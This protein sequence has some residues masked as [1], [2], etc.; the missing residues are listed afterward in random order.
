[1]R[2]AASALLVCIGTIHAASIS[3]TLDVRDWIADYQRPTILPRA[4][5]A[6][7]PSDAKASLLLAN[8][9]FP[10]P[11]IE[12]TEGDSIE[13]HVANNLIEVQIALEFEGLKLVDGPTNPIPQ[14]GGQSKYVLVASTSGVFSWHS[15]VASQAASGLKGAIV[16]HSRRDPF[17]GK[18]K[19]EMVIALSDARQRPSVCFKVDGAV[20]AA[21]PEIEKATLN[22]QWGDGSKD[23]PL[24]VVNVVKGECYRVHFLGMMTQT[25][26]HFSIRIQ[27]HSVQLLNGDSSTTASE[28]EVRAGESADT[29]LCA[30]A[31][32]G[33]FSHD[34]TISFDY[35]GKTMSKSFSAV[36]RYTRASDVAH[37]AVQTSASV[38]KLDNML[39]QVQG[40]GASNQQGSDFD[41]SHCDVHRIFEVRDAIVD[42]L[43]PTVDLGGSASRK[44]PND[45]P[46]AVRKAALLVNDSYPGPVLEATEGQL[47]C[48]TVLN[49]CDTDPM[50]IHWHGQHMKGHPAFD[51]VYGVT[52]AAINPR[53]G[54]LTYRWKANKGTHMYHA[55]MQALQADRGLKGAIVIHAKND[56][57]KHLYDE[58]RIVTISDEWVNPGTCMRTEGAQPGNPVCSEIDKATWNGQWGDGSDEY[59]W[60]MVTVEKGKCYRLRFIGI[61]GQAQNFQIQIAGHNMTLIAVDGEDVEPV[62]VSSMNL[63]A[64]ERYDVVVCADQEEGNYLMSAVYDLATFLETLPAPK[65][66]K[67]DSSKYWAFLN[68]AG[69]TEKPGRASKK[70]LGGYNPPPGTGGGLN[71]KAAGGF[72]WDTNTQTA[73]SQ[74]KNLNPRPE[75]EKA[76]ITYVMDVGIARPAFQAGVTPYA[77]SDV[78][79]MFTNRSSWKKPS[80]PLLHTKGQCGAEGVPYITVP[81][82]VSTVEVIINNLSPTAHVLHMHGMDFSVINYAPFSES[83][84]SA[85]HFD[86]FFLPLSIAKKL[87]CKGARLGDPSKDGP[88]NEYW[89]C[90]YDAEKDVKSQMLENPL[91]KDMISLWRRSWAVIRFKV[92]NPGVWL[93][94]CHMEQHIPTGQIMAF[95]LLPS[96]QPPIPSDVPT[97]GDCPIWSGRLAPTRPPKGPDFFV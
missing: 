95:N 32:G 78:M 97:E 76:D 36:L 57:H 62:V 26:P 21:C 70:A 69:H 90:P 54:S 60:P 66:P 17:A 81:E 4:A 6:D 42:Y 27:D 93:F 80:T 22:G 12:A 18:Y 64:G 34:Y 59:P 43:R 39:A 88:G 31:G 10:G 72:V 14:Q 11:A 8:N 63:H 61:M 24:P 38:T 73:W 44:A 71:P 67:V 48:V 55:H 9:S 37:A 30:N 91:R 46:L 74:V 7:L 5:P 23:W 52:Q 49:N 45:I 65:M 35:V 33:I 86:C 28:F 29:I 53:G 83:W 68:Y 87:D 15:T 16:V 19:S 40:Q 84:C 47:V 56:P 79:Y 85:A 75:F 89:G 3:Y 41:L 58:E 77:T 92:E 25:A 94:H 82:N 50:A 20:S 2:F 1:M 96:Q 13:V 51:G